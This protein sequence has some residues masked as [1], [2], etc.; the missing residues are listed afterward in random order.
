MTV[1][2]ERWGLG[3]H[4][5]SKASQGGSGRA[6]AAGAGSCAT[7]K[8]HVSSETQQVG[9]GEGWDDMQIGLGARGGE[10]QKERG[11]FRSR[12]RLLPR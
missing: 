1:K 2:A 4:C 11:H 3:G 7:W 8:S 5:Q 9:G 10:G 12:A 6:W